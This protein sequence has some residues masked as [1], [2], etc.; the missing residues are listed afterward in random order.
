MLKLLEIELEV[1]LFF[2]LWLR[3]FLGGLI[4]EVDC[5]N[6]VLALLAFSLKIFAAVPIPVLFN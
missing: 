2:E 1:V 4:V 6:C 3:P 5:P